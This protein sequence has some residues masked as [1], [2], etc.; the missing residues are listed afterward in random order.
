MIEENNSYKYLV[1]EDYETIV[2]QLIEAKQ[3]FSEDIPPFHTRYE[4]KLE[5]IIAQV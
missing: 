4:G 3:E 1:I 2:N 5:S